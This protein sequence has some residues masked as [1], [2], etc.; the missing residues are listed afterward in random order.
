MSI[1]LA[2]QFTLVDDYHGSDY[3]GDDDG[4]DDDDDDNQGGDSGALIV[5]QA[6]AHQLNDFLDDTQNA[7]HEEV[8]PQGESSSG[9]KHDD[10][11]DLFLST[12]KVVYLSLDVEEGE[13]V[14]NWTRETIKKSLG[15]NDEDNFT[16][17]FEKDMEDDA[18]NS[19]YM[20]KMVDE[21]D[22]FNEVVVEDKSESD[23]DVS[24][25]YSSKDSEDF[26]TFTELFRTHN[27][28]ELKR[29]VAEKLNTN[30]VPRTLTKEELR[31]ERKKWFKPLVEERKFKRPL[32]FFTSHSDESLGDILSWGYIEDLKVYAIKREFGVQYFILIKDIMTLPWWDVEELVKM[33]NIQQCQWGPEVR[34]H[35]QKLWYYIRGEVRKNFPEWKPQYPKRTIQIDPVT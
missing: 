1:V 4:D 11:V 34:H 3:G 2:Q 22:N 14:K 15:L 23:Q 6:G 35:K 31:E 12:P 8:H 33:K 29:K 18:P 25:P 20:F 10:P 24:F 26:P 7:E 13:L 32:K 30:G 17:D 28:D 27:E 9:T 16:F 5:R 19:E 21:A